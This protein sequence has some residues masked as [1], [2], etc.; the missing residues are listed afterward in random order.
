MSGIFSLLLLLLGVFFIRMRVPLAKLRPLLL[1]YLAVLLASVVTFYVIV[2][3]GTDTS[4][5]GWTEEDWSQYQQR[6]DEYYSAL[7]NGQLDGYEGARIVEQWQFNYA[8]DTL[9]IKTKNDRESGIVFIEKKETDDQSVD[10]ILYTPKEK[11]PMDNLPKITPVLEMDGSALVITPAPPVTVRTMSFF[12]D[13]TM[14]QFTGYNQNRANT[15]YFTSGHQVL[16][17]RIPK[18]VDINTRDSMNGIMMNYK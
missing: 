11:I 4:Q 8:Q 16:V 9:T 1:V 17:I 10:V 13:F 3:P 5:P 12:H 2:A 18:T 14:A 15:S 6:M 7:F